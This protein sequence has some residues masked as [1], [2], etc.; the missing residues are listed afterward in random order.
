[1]RKFTVALILNVI[2]LVLVSCCY[3]DDALQ[4]MINDTVG[5]FSQ[6]SYEETGN[7]ISCNLFLPEGYPGINKYPLVV[8]I[9]DEGT[10]GENTDAP[11][12]QGYGGIIWASDSEQKKRKCIVLVPQYP[13][14]NAA[15]YLNITENLIRAVIESFQVDSNRVYVT[16]QAMGCTMLMN[17]ANEHPDLFA[18]ELFIAGQENINDVKG[19]RKQKFFHIAAESDPKAITVQKNLMDKFHIDGISISRAFEW[20]AKMSQ[21]E[22]LK[23]LNVVISGSLSAKFIHFLKGTVLPEGAALNTPEHK[24]SFDAA[25]KIDALRDWIFLQTRK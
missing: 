10:T 9:A 11:L 6:F 14:N 7:K 3:A 25:Y 8:F 13:D 18:A 15:K 21:A 24:Y 23:A 17:I 16:G 22:F 12:R 1:M 19:L 5:K 2:A 20:D 4:T